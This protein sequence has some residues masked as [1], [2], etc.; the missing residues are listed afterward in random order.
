MVNSSFMA[1]CPPCLHV[2]LLAV[3]VCAGT[4]AKLIVASHA[5]SVMRLHSSGNE[6]VRRLLVAGLAAHG[7]K[8]R[9]LA[10]CWHFTLGNL[11]KMALLTPSGLQIEPFL[12]AGCTL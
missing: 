9:M 1:I 8:I 12:V 7:F 5:G 10:C 3:L 4:L 6:L 11:V 2:A